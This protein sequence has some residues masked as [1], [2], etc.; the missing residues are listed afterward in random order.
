MEVGRYSDVQGCDYGSAPGEL[1]IG[2]C[3]G[4]ATEHHEGR[5]LCEEH[6]VKV[7]RRRPVRPSSVMRVS[8]QAV[9]QRPHY[10]RKG[11]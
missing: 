6:A 7:D 3:P 10:R 4:P 9:K 8:D 5:A 11:R 1:W 2:Q